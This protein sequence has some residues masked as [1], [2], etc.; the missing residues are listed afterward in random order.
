MSNFKDERHRVW[1][2]INSM[3]PR[4]SGAGMNDVR[5][6]PYLI[7]H[8]LDV[9]FLTRRYGKEPIVDELNGIKVLRAGQ[10][11][12][13]I[14]PLR[15][16]VDSLKFLF[17]SKERPDVI[18]FRGYCFPFAGLIFFA[19]IFFPEIKI[20]VQP[21]CLGEDDP[22]TVLKKRLGFFQRAQMLKSDAIFAMNPVIGD[23]L[24]A[25]GFQKDRIFPVKNMVDVEKFTVLSAEEKDKRKSELGLPNGLIIVTL[26]I[27]DSRKGQALITQS[28]C[29]YMEHHRSKNIFLV[30]IGPTVKD[31]K[32]LN[33]PDRLATTRSEEERVVAC[34]KKAR[35]S[36]QVLLVGNKTSPAE[37]LS[38]SDIFIHCSLFEGEA[39]VVNEA[40]ASGLTVILPDSDVYKA[41]VPHDCAMHF[42]L[43]GPV[44]LQS[45]LDEAVE[46]ERLRDRYGKNARDHILKTRTAENVA[47]HYAGLLKKV[48]LYSAETV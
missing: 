47:E 14:A 42:Q 30:H 25:N 9:T 12:S 34:A 46:D 29:K 17:S 43:D 23:R 40:L 44:N 13:R 37:F 16:I 35:L 31:L 5:I 41:Q 10:M 19:K 26:G 21:A 18:R 27:L 48:C 33:R 2:V 38:A 36:K 22:V 39:N 32:Q 8:G 4:F 15:W 3:P 24:I 45:K 28:F 7:D 20:I 6:A 11:E 1:L